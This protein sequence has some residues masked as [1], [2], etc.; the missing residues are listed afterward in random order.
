[1]VVLGKTKVVF[2]SLSYSAEKQGSSERRGRAKEAKG[3]EREHK[4]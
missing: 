4:G 1:M 2:D 3:K